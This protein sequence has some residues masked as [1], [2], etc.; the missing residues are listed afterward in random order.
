MLKMLYGEIVDDDPSSAVNNLM[1]DTD[2][3]IP[4]PSATDKAKQDFKERIEQCKDYRFGYWTF[5]ALTF[6]EKLCCCIKKCCTLRYPWWRRNLIQFEK[7]KIAKKR[8]ME[9]QDL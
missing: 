7:F 9:E 5:L 2:E 3:S 1:N 8:L 6:F 4:K